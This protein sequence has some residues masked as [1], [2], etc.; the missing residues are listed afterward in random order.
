VP[1]RPADELVGLSSHVLYDFEMT[2]A[3]AKRVVDV[4]LGAPQT[5]WQKRFKTRANVIERDWFEQNAMLESML[6]HARAIADFLYKPAPSAERIEARRKRGKASKSEDRFADHW[7]DDPNPWR[8]ARGRR[9]KVL[10]T[11]ALAERVGREIAHLTSYR[12]GLAEK[13][14]DWPFFEVYTSLATPLETFA[15]MVEPALVCHDFRERVEAADSFRQPK[16]HVPRAP[17]WLT[18]PPSAATQGLAP[19]RHQ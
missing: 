11:A 4:V 19:D 10:R 18:A 15:R 1:A 14:P 2:E 13:G 12:A 17:M 7:F 5:A 6:I 3:L 16:A 9:P 8:K